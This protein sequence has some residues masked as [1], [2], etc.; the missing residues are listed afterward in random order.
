MPNQI[1][2]RRWN[3]AELESRIKRVFWSN[4]LQSDTAPDQI[5]LSYSELKKSVQQGGPPLSDKSFWSALK[6]LLSDGFLEKE[7]DRPRPRY[8]LNIPLGDNDIKSALLASDVQ[9]LEVAAQVGCQGNL[10][11]GY[12]LYAIDTLAPRAFI[13]DLEG[14]A[15]SFRCA[16]LDRAYDASDELISTIM[17]S[18]SHSQINRDE[19]RHIRAFLERAR[20]FRM[21]MGNIPAISAYGKGIE[22]LLGAEFGSA[23]ATEAPR[24]SAELV[25]RM[26]KNPERHFDR[27]FKPIITLIESGDPLISGFAHMFYDPARL[28]GDKLVDF[29][30]ALKRSRIQYS[31]MRKLSGRWFALMKSLR[32]TLIISA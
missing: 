7:S 1:P 8:R 12:A 25:K 5:W 19:R 30:C 22:H 31:E 9:R 24:L 16:V 18:L 23:L 13:R 20:E 17:R 10:R 27:F 2:I 28:T 4:S 3:R 15:E 29:R 21:G 6:T 14:I 32:P 11:K 26:W